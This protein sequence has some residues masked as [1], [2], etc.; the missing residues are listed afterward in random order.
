MQK[1]KKNYERLFKVYRNS[2]LGL[3]E[4][5]KKLWRIIDSPQKDEKETM[6]AINLI[7]Q[8]F[9]MRF[10]MIKSEPELIRQTQYMKIIVS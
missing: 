6:K 1:S 10:E 4:V 5:V 2:L 7:I 8:C 9:K 3:D